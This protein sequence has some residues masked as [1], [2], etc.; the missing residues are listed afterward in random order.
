MSNTNNL[1]H[2]SRFVKFIPEINTKLKNTESSLLVCQLEYWFSKYKDGFYKFME[3]CDHYHYRNGDSWTEE[4]SLTRKVLNK[5]FD[6]VGVRYKSKSAYDEAEDTF[7]GKLYASY[8]DRGQNKTFYIRNYEIEGDLWGFLKSF[9][10][11]MSSPKKELSKSLSSSS[12]KRPLRNDPIGRSPI[13][14]D[15]TKI[16]NI[17]I[18]P[19][20]P[21]EKKIFQMEKKEREEEVYEERKKKEKKSPSPNGNEFE[22]A[23]TMYQIWKNALQDH[24]P[25]PHLSPK[26]ASRLAQT[27]ETFFANS[28][29]SWK[30]YCARIRSSRFLT[31]QTGG[32]FKLWLVKALQADTIQKVREGAYGVDTTLQMH[33]WEEKKQQ[34]ALKV[35][36]I[37]KNIETKTT[38]QMDKKIRYLLLQKQGADVY[39]SWFELLSFEL[40]ETQIFKVIAPNPFHASCMEN[41]FLNIFDQIRQEVTIKSY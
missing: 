14:K 6:L 17:S 41:R 24:I 19:K 1:V 12:Q 8:Y 38:S 22:K 4:L 2:K 11:N 34:N 3:P 30:N 7:Q 5:A 27:L 16:I 23:K 9:L 25:T 13:Y 35:A 33:S 10:K 36:Q 15:N 37:Q 32:S 18:P 26:L 39:K 20:S 21:L 31:G 28:L 29:E 40:C